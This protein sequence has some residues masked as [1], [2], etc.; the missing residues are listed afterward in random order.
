MRHPSIDEV[1]SRRPE[2]QDEALCAQTDPEAFY[3]EKG[4]STVQAKRVCLACPVRSQCLSYALKHDERFGIWGGLSERERRKLDATAVDV[5]VRINEGKPP[6]ATLTAEEEAAV[7]ELLKRG[8]GMQRIWRE[9][10]C[11]Y[12]ALRRFRD[13]YIMTNGEAA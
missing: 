4:G 7:L 13:H 8:W 11:S 3:P 10:H 12:A 6:L 9:V 1:F 5:P 2:W